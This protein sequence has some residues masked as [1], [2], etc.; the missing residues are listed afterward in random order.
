[1]NKDNKLD[2][3][4]LAVFF[5][6]VVALAV[7]PI[8]MHT[9]FVIT[10]LKETAQIFGAT[11]YED[12]YR[13]IDTYSQC[14]AFA[15]VVFALIMLFVA[16]VCCVFLFR[17]AEKRSLAIVGA[18]AIYLV[19]ALASALMSDYRDVALYGQ[20]DRAEG[21]FTTACYFVMFLFTM[22]A[23]RKEQNFKPLMIAL[24]VCV[25]VNA[26]LG[27]FQYTGNNLESTEWFSKLVID[28]KYAD[29][30][31]V[32]GKAGNMV[33]GALYHYN[34]VGSFTR[35]GIPACGKHRAKRL[36]GGC[37]SGGCRRCHLY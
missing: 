12:S 10:D 21:L 17:H 2:L 16:G 11:Q 26:V 6:A 37:R 15:V 4:A 23:F 34:Y 31:G 3:T 7:I 36:R 19:M 5:P 35:G 13:L 29:E 18:S 30:I 32:G 33:Y 8:L 28:R 14:K 24:F 22:Y 9:T 1:M 20:F 27:I 25:G